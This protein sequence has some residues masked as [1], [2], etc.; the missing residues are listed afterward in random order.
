VRRRDPACRDDI[1][2]RSPYLPNRGNT[3]LIVSYIAAQ[4]AE[5]RSICTL[6]GETE[7]PCWM[8][9]GTL[10]NSGR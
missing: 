6:C 1:T 8:L 3:D 2:S 9:A 4:L 10:P 7:G 5:R